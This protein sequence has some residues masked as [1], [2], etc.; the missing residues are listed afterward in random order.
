MIVGTYAKSVWIL[1]TSQFIA[2]FSGFSM[3]VLAYVLPYDFCDNKFSKQAIIVSSISW[4]A[5]YNI[6]VYYNDHNRS[7]L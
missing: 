4:Y 1:A 5:L 6:K 7:V 2:G 3:V